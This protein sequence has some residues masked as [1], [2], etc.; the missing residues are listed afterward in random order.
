MNYRDYENII[1]DYASRADNAGVAADECVRNH[2]ELRRRNV[3][4]D[5][6]YAMKKHQHGERWLKLGT[7]NYK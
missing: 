1:N 2:P 3:Y 6:R 7:E 5:I 4:L